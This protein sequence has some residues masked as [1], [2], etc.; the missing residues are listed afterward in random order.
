MTMNFINDIADI[1]DI[2]HQIKVQLGTEFQN[3]YI[4]HT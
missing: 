2:V 3:T 4:I 1:L